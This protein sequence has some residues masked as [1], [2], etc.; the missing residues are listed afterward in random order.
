MKDRIFELSVSTEGDS[1]VQE[2]NIENLTTKYFGEYL[3]AL[4]YLKKQCSDF[5]KEGSSGNI[6]I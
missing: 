5:V 1:V 4:E 2:G 6:K 3:E